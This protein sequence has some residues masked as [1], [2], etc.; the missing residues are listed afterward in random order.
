MTAPARSS[1]TPALRS[2]LGPLEHL[3]APPATRREQ[4]WPPARLQAER[5]AERLRVGLS[6]VQL[7]HFRWPRPRSGGSR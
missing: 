7:K 1:I 2:P 3:D 4:H 5:L 6:M